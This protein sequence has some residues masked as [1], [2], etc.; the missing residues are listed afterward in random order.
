MSNICLNN[1]IQEKNWCS[2]N[3]D[4]KRLE[5]SNFLLR[6]KNQ[7]SESK[8]VCGFSVISTLKRIATFESQ[9]FHAFYSAKM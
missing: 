7:R 2:Q 8:T 1:T 6:L 3:F 9:R 5:C 4:F